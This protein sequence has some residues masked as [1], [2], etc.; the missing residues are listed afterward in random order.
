MDKC[1]AGRTGKLATANRGYIDLLMYKK[2]MRPLLFRKARDA[3]GAES[4][5]WLEGQ[6][7]HV[8]SSFRIWSDEEKR[9]RT[10]QAGRRPYEIKWVNLLVE[11]V[12]GTD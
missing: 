3:F 8:T 5:A 2:E 7:Q 4:H 12:F 9:D 1:K 6:V 10:W 11:V